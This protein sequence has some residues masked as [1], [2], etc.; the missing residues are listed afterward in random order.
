MCDC[1]PY[2]SHKR[3]LQ[4]PAKKSSL[5]LADA[6]I[7]ATAIALNIPLISADKQFGTVEEITLVKY[8][9]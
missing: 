4:N 3:G 1:L 8:E 2:Q 9:V 7:A 6:V 5:K